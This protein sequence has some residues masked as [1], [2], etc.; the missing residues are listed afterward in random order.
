MSGMGFR[1]RNAEA[2]DASIIADIYNVYIRDTIITFEQDPIDTAEIARRLAAIQDKRLPWLVI[3]DLAS[4]LC[5]YAYAGEWKPRAA[6]RYAV[7][8]SIYLD[9]NRAQRGMGSALYSELF[10]RLPKLGV[11]T[12]LAGIALPN[13]VSVGLHEKFGMVKVAHMSEVGHKF[14]RWIDVG[15]WQRVF[16]AQPTGSDLADS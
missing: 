4:Q 12:A 16:D 13:D 3:E 9:M 14:G 7:E 11:H 2:Q 5:G 15:Y 6:Y 8:V 10:E 1:I